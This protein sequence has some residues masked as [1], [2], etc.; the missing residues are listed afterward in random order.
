[1]MKPVRIA[2]LG[3]FALAALGVASIPASAGC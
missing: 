2:W 1:M 3:A